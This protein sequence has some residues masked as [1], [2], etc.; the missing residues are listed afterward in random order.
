MNILL[1]CMS[2]HHMCAVSTDARRGR[3]LPGNG[4]Q[5]CEP[6]SGCWEFRPGALE[7]LVFFITELLPSPTIHHFKTK[8]NHWAQWCTPI[9]FA[10][11]KAETKG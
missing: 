11:Q 5:S 8:T 4:V 7:E 2:E 6:S 10:T 1:A 3:H 9:I